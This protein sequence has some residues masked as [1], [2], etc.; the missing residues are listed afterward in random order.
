MIVLGID[1]G[2]SGGFAKLDHDGSLYVFDMPTLMHLRKREIDAAVLADYLSGTA[3]HAFVERAA[4]MP[5][6]GVSSMFSFGRAYGTVIGIL[7]AFN[8]PMTFVSPQ[9]WKAALGVPKEK[10]GARARASQLLPGHSSNWLRSKDHGRAEAA[11]IALY[12]L[13]T[14]QGGAP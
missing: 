1:P 2:L 14:L 3:D 10:D 8:V 5:K 7:A 12:G 9:K 13:K 6:Q 4:A 11:L